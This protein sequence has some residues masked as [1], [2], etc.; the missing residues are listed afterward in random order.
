MVNKTKKLDLC[1]VVPL[2]FV[3]FLCMGCDKGREVRKYKKKESPQTASGKV[4][5]QWDTP[6]GWTGNRSATGMRLAS[7]S[8]NNGDRKSLCTIIP[9]KGA[10]G[11]IRANIIRWLGQIDANIAT[12][13][14]EVETFIDSG[15]A[16]RTRGNFPAVFYDFTGLTG[17]PGDQSILVTIISFRDS[18]IFIKMTGEKAHLLENRKKFKSLS[19]SFRLK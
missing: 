7:F 11:G 9:L 12:E 10:A 13:S 17:S 8:V 2:L 5:F 15:E 18:S 4:I 16:F 1:G 6:R 19:Q 14:K 3:F